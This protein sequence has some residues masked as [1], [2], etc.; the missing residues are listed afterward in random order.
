MIR[1]QSVKLRLWLKTRV[2]TLFLQLLDLL[3][4]ISLRCN[5]FSSGG[6]DVFGFNA[7]SRLASTVT[8]VQSVLR[9]YPAWLGRTLVQISIQ[10][11]LFAIN[12]LDR[13]SCWMSVHSKRFLK[14]I[15]VPDELSRSLLN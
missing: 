6:E 9:K 2:A 8:A 7:R 14:R 5:S 11:V 4:W 15:L 1:L 12:D 10:S 3:R 13:K